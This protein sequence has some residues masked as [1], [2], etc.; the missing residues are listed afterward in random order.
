MSRAAFL[1]GAFVLIT[2]DRQET[3]EKKYKATRL[4]TILQF[5]KDEQIGELRC[6]KNGCERL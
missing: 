2:F 1:M 3:G 6:S 5:G 4:T